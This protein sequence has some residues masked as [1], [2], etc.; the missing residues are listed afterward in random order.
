MSY[1]VKQKIGKNIYAYEA[2]SYYDK[3]KKQPRQKRT[4][5][6]RVNPETN[7]IVKTD[8]MK[9]SIP[10]SAK[11][12]GLMHL[13]DHVGESIGLKKALFETFPNEWKKILS[14]S[15]FELS[16]GKPL[17]LFPQ[18]S[19]DMYIP[20]P[21][22]REGS[23]TSQSISKLLKEIG[24]R[25]A[26]REQFFI[27]WI[28]EVEDTSSVIFDITSISSYSN[29]IDTVEWGYNRDKENLPQINLGM[30]FG[31]P[32][33]LPLFY[34]LY[35]G[36][37][38]DI[39][40]LKNILLRLNSFGIKD[41]LFVMDRGFF[42]RHN[43][44]M[45]CE[46]NIK[47]IIPMSFTTKLS[48][49][50][51]LKHREDLS[52]PLNFFMHNGNIIFSV[53]EP[54]EIDNHKLYAFIYLDKQREAEETQRFLKGLASVEREVKDHSFKD[55]GEAKEFLESYRRDISKYFIIR[56]N[57]GKLTLLR[58][59]DE[60]VEEVNRMG[61]MI[62]ITNLKNMDKESVLFLYKRR[63]EVERLFDVLK[64]EIDGDRI[65][66]HPN[67]T[68]EGK[69][70]LLF[71]TLILIA[72]LDRIMVRKG[73]YKE[74]SLSHIIYEL[75]KIKVVETNNGKRFLTEISKIQ[76]TTYKEFEVPI[77]EM[78]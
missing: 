76:K 58:K 52:S 47:F 57:R 39:V 45:I 29:C 41:T 55:V 74:Q 33:S 10:K 69:L 65:R 61:K 66:N 14:L 28:P 13:L 51:L 7:E 60:I 25:D 36:S 1:I 31:E 2:V 11:S 44:E 27:N 71:I 26:K 53:E 22:E 23:I 56:L 21:H 34:S 64:N 16:E 48:K 32:S 78:T 70:F 24:E 3:K 30:V 38:P 54:I 20:Y 15:F 17:Y 35:Q 5:L 68:M 46:S 67:E 18:W 43:I 42:S 75:K 9:A 62:I 6:G 37:I 49:E 72:S 12:F 77:P 59:V 40:T 73:L 50:L 8:R 4:Y 63:N 19:E